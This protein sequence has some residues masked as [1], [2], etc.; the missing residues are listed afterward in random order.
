MKKYF[1]I[2]TTA[3]VILCMVSCV[4]ETNNIEDNSTKISESSLSVKASLSDVTRSHLD[5]DG[6]T[7]LWDD[8]DNVLLYSTYMGTWDWIYEEAARLENK[9]NPNEGTSFIMAIFN[10]S[11]KNRTH[12]WVRSCKR[13]F[14]FSRLLPLPSQRHRFVRM[15]K[16]SMCLVLCP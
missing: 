16:R 10:D 14:I 4:K 2:L 11:A 3:I 6:Y 5:E 9:L 12:S 1:G 7:L 13:N 8:N 15:R